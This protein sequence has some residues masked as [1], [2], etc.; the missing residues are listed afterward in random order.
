M[1][2]AVAVAVVQERV[3]HGRGGLA[4]RVVRAAGYDAEVAG[5]Q[6]RVLLVGRGRG[7]VRRQLGQVIRVLV[8]PG[9]TGMADLAEQR[10]ERGQE[11]LTVRG[12]VPSVLR[13]QNITAALFTQYIM[14]M[15]F[16]LLT[17]VRGV[18]TFTA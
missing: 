16:I 9:R 2:S 17:M 13:E 14:F 3:G 15:H 6:H 12:C 1:R 11:L 10:P 18:P 7:Q 8:Q 5:A 4:G